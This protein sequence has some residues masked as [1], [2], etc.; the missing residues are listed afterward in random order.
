MLVAVR[1]SVRGSVRVRVRV[2]VMVELEAVRQGEQR[3]V[4]PKAMVLSRERE[5]SWIEV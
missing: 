3:L 2:R 4:T 5:A 1:V